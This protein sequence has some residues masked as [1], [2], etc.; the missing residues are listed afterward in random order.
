M[1]MS[2]SSLQLALIVMSA[3]V[4][5]GPDATSYRSSRSAG[6]KENERETAEGAPTRG[7]VG[8]VAV[9]LPVVDAEN[10]T[11][12]LYGEG[13]LVVGSRYDMSL[14]VDDRNRDVREILGRRANGCKQNLSWNTRSLSFKGEDDLAILDASGREHSRGV[15][16]VPGEMEIC[17]CLKYFCAR[18]VVA[19]CPHHS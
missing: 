9:R 2:R 13:D 16:D 4:N 10:S 5:E 3:D 8:F 19:I 1:A 7:L 12:S 11:R 15:G 14:F 17:S 18:W 6:L